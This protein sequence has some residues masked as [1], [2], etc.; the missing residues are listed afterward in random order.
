MVNGQQ[1]GVVA[2]RGCFEAAD[3]TI[4]VLG[5]PVEGGIGPDCIRRMGSYSPEAL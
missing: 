4:S 5:A 1:P 2:A 3:E